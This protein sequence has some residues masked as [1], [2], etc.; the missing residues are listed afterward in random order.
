MVIDIMEPK[1]IRDTTMASHP[2]LIFDFFFNLKKITIFNGQLKIIYIFLKKI[3]QR[4]LLIE[5]SK[6]NDPK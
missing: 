1:A 2:F 5:N 3:E 4:H 6:Y